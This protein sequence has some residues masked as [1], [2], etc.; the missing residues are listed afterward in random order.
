MSNFSSRE[1]KAIPCG[2]LV[3]KWLTSHPNFSG[4]NRESW[5]LFLP[6][7]IRCPLLVGLGSPT[8]PRP[9]FFTQ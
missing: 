3:P 5:V 4:L 2:K 9:H 7:L 1:P 8:Q 6:T